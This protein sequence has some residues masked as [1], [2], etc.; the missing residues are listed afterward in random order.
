MKKYHFL[1]LKLIL[2]MILAS[3][4]VQAQETYGG[5]TLYTVR[6]L[7]NENP[8]ETL[9]E[10]ANIGYKY[11]EATGYNE[12]KFYGMEPSEFKEYLTSIGLVPVSSHFAMVTLDNADQLIAD[13]KAA[14]FQYFVIPIPPMGHFTF[15]QETMTMGMSEDVEWLTEVFNTIGKKCK[16]AG[17]ELLYHNHNFEFVENSKGVV[18]MDYFLE[19]TSADT[20]NFQLDLYWIT[21]AGKDPVAYFEK[22]PGR[23][24]MWHVKD[25]DKEGKF[26]PVGEGT[27]DFGRILEKKEVSGLKY[28]IV[29]QDMTWE[30]NPLEAI[31]ISHKGLKKFGFDKF[32]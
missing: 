5:A 10:V 4:T 7:M 1:T 3:V 31:K 9:Q 2:L 29:E 21:A 24:K 27:I 6:D 12:G 23:F 8:K 14:G 26:A 32:Q 25:M 20:V 13:A 19:N 16:D 28:Y 15:D 17:L 22:Y 11:I 18:P 30:L